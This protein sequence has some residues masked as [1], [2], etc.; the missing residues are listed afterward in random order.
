MC[1][2]GFFTILYPK[3]YFENWSI[4]AFL[5]LAMRFSRF[6]RVSAHYQFENRSVVDLLT[7]ATRFS[8]I[9]QVSSLILD[10]K[11]DQ[12]SIVNLLPRDF[13][14]YY[15]LLA[16]S[17]SD[18]WSIFDCQTLSTRYSRVL[19]VFCTLLCGNIS[20]VDC[21]ILDTI[22]SRML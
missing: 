22:F 11:I 12:W 9:L 19:H 14:G 3:N 4:V 15:K 8:R 21:Q 18:N 2:I 17:L 20:M 16:H 13:H 10:V 7:L 5:A 1:T 6:V